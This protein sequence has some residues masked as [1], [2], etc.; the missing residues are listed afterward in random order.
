MNCPIDKVPLVRKVYEESIE[1][2]TCEICSG[3][4]LDKGELEKL[5]E[6]KINDYTEELKKIPDYIGKSLLLAKSKSRE[7]IDCPVCQ[8]KLER[9]EYGFASLIMIDSCVNGHG[10]WL[11][12]GELKDL[13]I[14]YER[15]RI[16]TKKMRM[17]FFRSLLGQLA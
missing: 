5:Q 1:I 14:F 15:S 2:D 8:R 11:D 9:R 3:V 7:E 4:W 6:I 10:L 17:G 12:K 16:E 13:E